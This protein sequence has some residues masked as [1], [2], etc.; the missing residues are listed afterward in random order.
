MAR[1]SKESPFSSPSPGSA[2][3]P[4][5]R[6]LRAGSQDSTREDG[7][8]RRALGDPTGSPPLTL[9]DS[10][11]EGGEDPTLLGGSQHA[12]PSDNRRPRGRSQR[13]Q[14]VSQRGPASG[15]P[16]LR[17]LPRDDRFGL[18]LLPG[19]SLRPLLPQGEGGGVPFLVPQGPPL[20]GSS[21][22]HRQRGRVVAAE[23]GRQPG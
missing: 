13:A 11:S 20:L 6:S 19:G 23:V 16:L 5:P 4:R 9:R 15:F 21:P 3:L 7:R 18:P 10:R 2:T 8:L 22:L 1:G 14:G 17:R 12:Q